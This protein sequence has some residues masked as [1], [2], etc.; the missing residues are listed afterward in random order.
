MFRVSKSIRHAS[1]RVLAGPAKDKALNTPFLHR[2]TAFQLYQI[3]RV[4]VMAGVVH[5]RLRTAIVQQ[6]IDRPATSLLQFT[7]PL[8]NNLQM[9]RQCIYKN[10][11]NRMNI[12]RTAKFLNKLSQKLILH[13]RKHH[14]NSS[15][16]TNLRQKIQV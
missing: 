16:E 7:T 12:Q 4:R 13:V 8:V 6:Q 9:R 1:T 3:N 15:H 10:E 2:C 14:S 11:Y 5:D